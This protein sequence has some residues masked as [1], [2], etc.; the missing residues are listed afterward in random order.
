MLNRVT[1]GQIENKSILNVLIK[2]I[3]NILFVFILLI[4]CVIMPYETLVL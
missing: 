2:F 4:H 1:F 3:I